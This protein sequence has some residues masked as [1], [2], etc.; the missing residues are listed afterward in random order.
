MLAGLIVA[1]VIIVVAISIGK[2][3]EQAVKRFLGDDE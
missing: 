3:T 1:I 2:A